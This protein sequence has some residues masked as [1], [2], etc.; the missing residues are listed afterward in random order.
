MLELAREPGNAAG[1]CRQRG[2]DRA[3]FCEWKRRFQR[4]GFEGPRDL[5]PIHKSHPPTTPPE[6][7]E[8]IREAGAG[9]SGLGLQATRGDAGHGGVGGGT[10][11]LR[12]SPRTVS[13]ITI[14]TIPNDSGPGTK[15]KRRLALEARNAGTVIEIT[16]EQPAFLEDSNPCFR[17]RHVESS[18]PGELLSADSFFMG[19]LKGVGKVCL[20]AVADTFGSHAFGFLHVSRQPEAAVAVLHGRPVALLP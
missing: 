8:R 2:L 12:E 18:A 11:S 1:A 14:R 9:P 5:P 10:P 4:Q 16:P 15:V 20:H 13:A 6:T 7:A 3:G 17:E 19:S